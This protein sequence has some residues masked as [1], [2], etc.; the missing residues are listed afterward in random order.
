MQQFGMENI[1]RL[2]ARVSEVN[3][4]GSPQALMVDFV[5]RTED[6]GLRE[7][8]R[9]LRVPI[10]HDDPMLGKLTWSRRYNWF[11]GNAKW[12]RGRGWFATRVRV[13]L[14]TGTAENLPAALRV[15]HA[16]W[17]DQSG[18]D[19][20]VRKYAAE[21]LLE[22][23]ND[24]W[25]G[26]SESPL[27]AKQFMKRMTLE[28]ISVNADGTF[29]FWHNDGGLFLGHSIQIRGNLTDGPTCADIPG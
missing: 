22:L 8:Q 7:F 1:V 5:G 3:V 12:H 18:W 27:T 9:Q 15:A 26:E 13:H 10:V 11:D 4:F 25:L 29:D 20:R 28:T 21:N 14:L 2:R 23:K 24:N 16:L 17:A 6:F 19:D